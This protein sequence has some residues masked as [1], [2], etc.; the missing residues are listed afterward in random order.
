GEKLPEGRLLPRGGPAVLE[1]GPGG[2]REPLREERPH[3]AHRGS[4]VAL[5]KPGGHADLLPQVLAAALDRYRAC[6]ETGEGL[7]RRE[8]PVRD[9]R[10]AVH[11]RQRGPDLLGV[12]E[13]M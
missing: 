13:A 5:L 6:A 1:A 4:E 3:V 9:E 2:Q 7:G 10:E 8:P 11:G 12:A